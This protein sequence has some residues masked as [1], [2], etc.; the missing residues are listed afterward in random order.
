MFYYKTIY[1]FIQLFYNPE[2]FSHEKIKVPISRTCSA[3][4]VFSDLTEINV[5]FLETDDLNWA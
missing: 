5:L 2:H 3:A 4:L 1:Q